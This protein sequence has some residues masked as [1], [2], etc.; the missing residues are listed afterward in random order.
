MPVDLYMAGLGMALTLLI[1]IPFGYWRAYAS[2]YKRRLEWAAAVHLP[3]PLV[4][5]FRMMAGIGFNAE[6]AVFI[7]LFVASY[8][9]G[10]R[11]GGMLYRSVVA[12]TGLETRCFLTGLRRLLLFSEAQQR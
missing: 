4:V 2:R 5:L 7:A 12:R 8:F 6:G 11:L 9:A 1:N 3:V 10:Q